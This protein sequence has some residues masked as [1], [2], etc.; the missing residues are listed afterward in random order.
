MTELVINA[1]SW[2]RLS[3]FIAV[4]LLC[5]I[6]ENKLPRRVL[7][8]PRWFRWINNLSLAALN[9]ATIILLM[10]MVAFQAAIIANDKQWGLLHQLALPDWLA[11]FIAIMLLDLIIYLQHLSFHRFKPL[12]KLHRMHH[13]DLDVDVTTSTR[14]HPI[15]IILSMIVKIAAVFAMGVS[16]FAIVVFEI[17]LNAS[18]MF[19][20]SNAKLPLSI[21]A[22][23]R[24]FVVTPDM[25]RVHHSII[26]KET[27]SNFGFFLSVWDRWFN[28]YRAQPELGHKNM[29]IGVPEIR[30]YQEQ[31]LDKL[32][33]QPFRY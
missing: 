3:I 33:T 16:P 25:H 5:T 12:W 26:V 14:F 8:V 15:E 6:W 4:L 31:R 23:L 32:I 11:S 9:S 1:P 28:T 29:V 20:H 13:A 24:K 18:A 27:H 21:D 19:N 7:T 17:V 30:D 10:P 22:I 2:F